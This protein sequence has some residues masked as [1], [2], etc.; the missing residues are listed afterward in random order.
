MYS[1]SDQRKYQGSF[2]HFFF[3]GEGGGGVAISE[4]HKKTLLLWPEHNQ[5]LLCMCCNEHWSNFTLILSVYVRERER[6]REIRGTL[7]GGG[8]GERT[9]IK[10]HSYRKN[11]W[12]MWTFFRCPLFKIVT[13]HAKYC[14]T[15]QCTATWSGNDAVKVGAEVSEAHAAAKVKGLEA[16]VVDNCSHWGIRKHAA[17]TKCACT[18]CFLARRNCQLTYCHLL[19]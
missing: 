4:G 14:H 13:G 12:K 15:T 16:A 5:Q 3:K 9:V 17:N 18:L 19:C 2:V 11:T 10:K 8:G 6:L 7:C 1:K